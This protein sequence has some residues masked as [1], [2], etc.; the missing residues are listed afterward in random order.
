M[1]KKGFTLVELIIVIILIALVA[2]LAT[3]N[4][5]SMVQKGRDKEILN[6]A[7]NFLSDV[8]YKISLNKYSAYYPKNNGE[9]TEICAN[10]SLFGIDLDKDTDG[11]SY[12]KNESCVKVFLDNGYYK[13]YIKLASLNGN[14]VYSKGISSSKN[15]IAYVSEEDLSSDV[16]VKY[17]GFSVDTENETTCIPIIIESGTN[18]DNTEED[19]NN[20][21]VYS[22]NIQS[23][24]TVNL[25]TNE[26]SYTSK[27]TSITGDIFMEVG[28]RNCSK[29]EPVFNSKTG[30]YT[31]SDVVSLNSTSLD[32]YYCDGCSTTATGTGNLICYVSSYDLQAN[33]NFQVY[34]GGKIYSS[35]TNEASST[36]YT[37]TSYTFDEKTGL[38]TLTNPT[39]RLYSDANSIYTCDSSLLK[40]C[41][42]MYKKISVSENNIIKA[43]I[44]TA[45]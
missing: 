24:V 12:D 32:G 8:K 22:E 45:K 33:S 11:N 4:V 13:Y 2:L 25:I 28:T 44:Y 18:D 30:T 23:N 21:S 39:K 9:C 31:L 15:K 38:Y 42:T 5:I 16:V 41:Y 29:T 10:S 43:D 1:N 34:I 36:K 7:Y 26:G 19:D 40:S 37:S 14:N 27:V 20:E 17:D 35:E 3:P 6:D